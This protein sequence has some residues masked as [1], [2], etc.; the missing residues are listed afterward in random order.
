MVDRRISSDNFVTFVTASDAM[1]GRLFAQWIVEKLNGKG[2][3]VMLAGQAG[4][5]PNEY[6]DRSRH[7]KSSSNI[8]ASRFSTRSIPTG[9]P[10]KGKQVM[11]AVIAKYGHEINA[12]WSTHGLQTPGSIEAFI[13][14]GFK[15]GEIPP[16]TTAD[17]NGP[18]AD[19]DQA[20]GA[21]ARQSAI[22][23]RWAAPQSTSP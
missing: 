5:S 15:A 8:P 3:V 11:Q 17:V 12:V 20:Q 23:R 6:R 16:H 10:G 9:A 22:R 2:N 1:M 13:E 4:S 19:G 21:D 14:A 18:Y 7:A